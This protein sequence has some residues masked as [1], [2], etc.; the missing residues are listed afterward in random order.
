MFQQLKAVRELWEAKRT[1]HGVV[2]FLEPALRFGRDTDGRLE[3]RMQMDDFVLAYIY[4]VITAFVVNAGVT[5]QGEPV[6]TAQQVFDRLFPRQG[7]LITELC[8]VRVNHKDKDFMTTVDLASTETSHAFTSQGQI[9]PRG[10]LDH[11]LA[12]HHKVP[13]SS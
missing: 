8:T 13:R 9:L 10:L 5:D 6:F 11:I 1:A 3:L 12:N 7:R 4:G 2:L